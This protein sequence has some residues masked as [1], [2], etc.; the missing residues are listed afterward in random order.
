MSGAAKPA[1]LT[2]KRRL[3]YTFALRRCAASAAVSRCRVYQV[4]TERN[5]AASGSEPTRADGSREP[6]PQALCHGAL[7]LPLASSLARHE[8]ENSDRSE[9]VATFGGGMHCA[10]DGLCD[11]T[12]EISEFNGVVGCSLQHLGAQQHL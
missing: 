9:R 8:A 6:R 4:C 12:S 10:H 1:R 2:R 5:L 3:T 7:R 11:I